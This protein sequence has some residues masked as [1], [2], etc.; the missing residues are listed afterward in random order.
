MV[1]V[2]AETHFQFPGVEDAIDIFSAPIPKP[3]QLG[4]VF[5]RAE[6]FVDQSTA[7]KVQRKAFGLL[8]T[9]IIVQGKGN[10]NI[11]ARQPIALE[12]PL[13]VRHHQGILNI[14]HLMAQVLRVAVQ[15]KACSQSPMVAEFEIS[16]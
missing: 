11:I 5:A 2:E 1:G 13:S 3:Y 4:G 16:A 7:K 14:V 10:T 6:L 8:L 12:I 15:K 9:K